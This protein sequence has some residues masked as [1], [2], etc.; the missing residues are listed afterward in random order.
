MNRRNEAPDMESAVL[1]RFKR[2]GRP[3]GQES[4]MSLPYF[5]W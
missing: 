1:W 3:G 4:R 5:E 2:S